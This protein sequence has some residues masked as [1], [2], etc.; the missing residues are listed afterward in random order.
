M[1]DS[2]HLRELVERMDRAALA[3]P[4][5]MPLAL[6]E[7]IA[8]RHRAVLM[9]RGI[10]AAAALGALVVGGLVLTREPAKP[11]PVQP[12]PVVEPGE[13]AP[14]PADLSPER[15]RFMLLNLREL[16]PSEIESPARGGSDSGPVPQ[17]GRP[18]Q[19]DREAEALLEGRSP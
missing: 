14:A 6:Q 10:V 13:E 8:A 16:S 12:T 11:M 2:R 15:R 19:V 9:Q 3:D 18:E 7:A 4:P 1:T 17:A 5:P